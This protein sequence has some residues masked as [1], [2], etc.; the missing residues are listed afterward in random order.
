MVEV[1]VMQIIVRRHGVPRLHPRPDPPGW[2][3]RE[4]LR[5]TW[6]TEQPNDD[7]E[8]ERFVAASSPTPL[9]SV[10]QTMPPVRAGVVPRA[11]LERRL[12]AADTKLTVVVAPAGW[13]K[14]SLLTGWAHSVRNDT[15][16]AWVSLDE[17]DDEPIRFWSYVITSLT[18]VSDQISTAPLDALRATNDGLLTQALPMLLNELAELTTTHVLVLDDF[19]VITNHDVHESLE[20]LL[21]YLPPTL[22]IVIA[23]R[24]DPPL[25]LARMRVRGELTEVRADD[26]RFSRDESASTGVGGLGDRS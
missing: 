3:A 6:Q 4:R 10:K 24:W 14:T 23:S 25:P 2:F 22:R 9:L 16:I 21:A 12:E 1:V 15:P 19:H 18:R 11:R 17:T 26:L 20:F 7:L 13:G 8:I 5:A